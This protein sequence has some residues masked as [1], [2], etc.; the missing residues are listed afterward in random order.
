MIELLNKRYSSRKYS[1]EKVSK[2]SLDYI[3]NCML[4]S[5]SGKNKNPWEFIL[6]NDVEVIKQLALAKTGGAQF[7]TETQH[8]I[9][10]LGL[11]EISDTWIEDTS[12]TLT[13]G[14]LA[15]AHLNLGSCWIQSR[16]RHNNEMSSED[17]IKNLLNIPDNIRVIGMLSIG[18]PLDEK[19]N[20]KTL[21]VE[22][23]SFDRYKA[24]YITEA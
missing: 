24:P 8:V 14:H 7:L 15:A 12:I 2:E 13:I 17:F 18:H 6:I 16:N 3:L 19:K 9:V 22:K 20:K 11:E 4:L 1:T 21:Q 23:I 10:A 5:P